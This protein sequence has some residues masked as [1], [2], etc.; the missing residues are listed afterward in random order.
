M[1]QTARIANSK[2]PL[3]AVCLQSS[4]DAVVEE[5]HAMADL[6]ASFVAAV[7]PYYYPSTQ[8]AI[9]VHFSRIADTSPVPLILYNIPQNT[10]APMSVETVLELSNH[11]NIVGIKDSSGNFASFHRTLME[12]DPASFS[13]IQGEDLLDAAS[14]AVG[15]PAIV[16]GLGNVCIE[17]YVEMHRAAKSGDRTKMLEL[18]RR[19]Y[20]IAKIVW[21][22]DGKA[23]PAIKAAAELLGRGNR[24]MKVEGLTLK[25]NE[26]ETVRGVLVEAGVL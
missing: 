15:A 16:T 19:I 17:H 14:F 26:V 4:T 23:I 2:V 8:E 3:Y 1:R 25:P 21:K 20:A 24:R 13:C 22:L 5:V 11:P 10:H 12:T 18:Q 6:G 9:L 7:P